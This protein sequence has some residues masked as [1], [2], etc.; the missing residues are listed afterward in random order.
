[1]VKRKPVRPLR[2]FCLRALSSLVKAQVRKLAQKSVAADWYYVFRG[3]LGAGAKERVLEEQV[4]L[5]LY[6]TFNA[7]P[8]ISYFTLVRTSTPFTGASVKTISH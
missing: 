2:E 4:L 7:V 1:M 8:S 5:E 6:H 3:E